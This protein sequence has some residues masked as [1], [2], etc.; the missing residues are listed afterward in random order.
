[1]FEAMKWPWTYEPFD[2]SG[3]IPDFHIALESKPMICE[4][5][6]SDEDF[7]SAERKIDLSEWEGPAL[8]V[9]HDV[10]RAVCGRIRAFDG[11]GFSWSV[12]RFFWCISCGRHSVLEEDGN[13]RCPRCGDGYGNEH[14]GE[15]DVSELWNAAANAVQWKGVGS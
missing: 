13:W 2:L 3:Y 10:S 1:M 5:K 11:I 9:G 15:F 12:A 8:I 6:A 14:V 7:A 4:V